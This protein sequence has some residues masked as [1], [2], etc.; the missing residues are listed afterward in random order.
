[1]GRPSLAAISPDP[2]CVRCTKFI[3]SPIMVR[4]IRLLFFFGW[5]FSTTQQPSL[6][7]KSLIFAEA[8]SFSFLLPD[9][10]RCSMWSRLCRPRLCSH[11]P[12]EG[13]W[14][15]GRTHTQETAAQAL[16]GVTPWSRW[17]IGLR[18]RIPGELGGS[19][20]PFSFQDRRSPLGSPAQS[21]CW[22][23]LPL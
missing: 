19:P 9:R 14:T 12:W 4:S 16:L 7:Q 2:M 8:S 21:L 11:F 18:K 5:G 1:M 22:Q 17:Y 3:G 23:H 15:D 13:G 10:S 20:F 6:C